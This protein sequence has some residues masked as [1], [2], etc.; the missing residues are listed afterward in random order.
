MHDMTA[1]QAFTPT[2]RTPDLRQTAQAVSDLGL[3]APRG[4]AQRAAFRLRIWRHRR[5]QR[6]RHRRTTG[7]RFDAIKV[8]PRYGVMPLLPPVEVELF[9]RRYA[10]PIGIA[11]MGGPSLVWPGADLLHG[12][13]GAGGARALYARRRRRRHHRAGGRGRA[14]R[15]LAAA[16]PLCAQRPQDRLRPHPPR[17]RP[18][19]SRCWRSRSTC[20][21][22]PR[23]RARA[24]PG[25]GGEFRPTPRMIYEM[26]VRPKWLLAL[27]RHGYPR[28]AT[29]G[30]YAK[31]NNTNEV[32]GF[33]RREM[34]GAFSW[35]EV[36]RY[37][38][39]WKGPMVVKGILH[40]A[41]A[42]KAVALGIEG[43]WVSNHGGRQIEAL[44]P[45]DRRLAGDRVGRRQAR[46][47]RVRQRHPLRPGRDA[48]ARARRRCR[49]RRQVVPVGGGGARRR[50][51]RPI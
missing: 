14:R 50:R 26:M 48:R 6:C 30:Q 36:A 2:G 8:A 49:L 29:I 40:P 37:R 44:I 35:E 21:C 23:A 4:A 42:E 5:R 19:R 24:M 51:A 20:R 15:V 10:A 47:R 13:G 1:R 27:L 22:A 18:P 11:P 41:D 34:G 32:I 25:L 31:S 39:A 45:T 12:Q 46:H 7:R 43:V 3:S 38:D 33:A 9:G 16:L 17:R 28:F